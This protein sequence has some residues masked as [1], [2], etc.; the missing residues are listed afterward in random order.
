MTGDVSGEATIV[1]S[2]PLTAYVLPTSGF[3][4]GDPIEEE[5]FAFRSRGVD[6]RFFGLGVWPVVGRPREVR[7]VEFASLRDARI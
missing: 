6:I 7:M 3:G 1:N 2:S 5:D 4:P